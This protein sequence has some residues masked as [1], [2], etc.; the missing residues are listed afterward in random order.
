[1]FPQQQMINIFLICLVFIENVSNIAS[2][3]DKQ[4]DTD[5]Y[6]IQLNSQLL[7][8]AHVKNPQRR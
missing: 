2:D 8:I 7:G 1:M 4:T 6:G 5:L 3:V